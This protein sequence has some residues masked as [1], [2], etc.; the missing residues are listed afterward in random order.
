M[1]TIVTNQPALTPDHIT[2]MAPAIVQTA[3]THPATKGQDALH[4]AA[5]FL[6]TLAQF[7]APTF[8]VTRASPRTQAE[9][10]LS[11]GALSALLQAFTKPYQ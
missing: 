4:I 7:M 3:L 8:Q 5:T 11:V 9:I 6:D 2:A 1:D 10:A